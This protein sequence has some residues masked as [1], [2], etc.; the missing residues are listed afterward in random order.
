MSD[1]R[2]KKL[3]TMKVKILKAER[4]NLKTREKTNDQMVEL[5][6]RILKDESRK[7]Y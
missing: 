6:R 5:I 1:A 4:Q 2:E 3:N 7:N